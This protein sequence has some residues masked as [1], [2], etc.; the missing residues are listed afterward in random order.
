MVQNSP[1]Q[2]GL[3]GLRIF[4]HISYEIG[5]KMLQN[6]EDEKFLS[7]L[8]KKVVFLCLGDWYMT[9]FKN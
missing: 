6:G 4:C 2:I 7:L 5:S 8:A 3:E 1:V 9:Y